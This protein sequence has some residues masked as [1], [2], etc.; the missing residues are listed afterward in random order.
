M[1]RGL[2]AT[3]TKR[4]SHARKDVEAPAGACDGTLAKADRDDLNA[5]LDEVLIGGRE[6]R[7]VVIVD[8]D[9][10]WPGHFER[11]RARILDALAASPGSSTSGR[12]RSRAWRPSRRRGDL[13][14]PA[15]D[16][17]GYVLRV[18]EPGHRMLRTPDLGVHVHVWA[19]LV[20]EV[21]RVLI[22]RD[23][24]RS[25]AQDRTA[26]ERLKRELADRD[27]EARLATSASATS[28]R[29]PLS[30]SHATNAGYA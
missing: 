22:F 10:A 5:Y 27:W 2:S 26:Y 12:R 8:P 13:V 24:L 15:L 9:P 23:R 17:A 4:R 30:G 16:G 7:P 18:R 3:A 6:R 20:P 29:V 14:V 19:E 28:A 21:A 25:S 1:R 11:E